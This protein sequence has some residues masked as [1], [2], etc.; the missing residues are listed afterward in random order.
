MEKKTCLADCHSF[1][2]T[3]YP[4]DY[5]VM[6]PSHKW[7]AKSNTKIQIIDNFVL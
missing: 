3:F 1:Q 7:M 5:S 4:C 2:L 6:G